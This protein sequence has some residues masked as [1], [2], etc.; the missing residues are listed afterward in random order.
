MTLLVLGLFAVVVLAGVSRVGLESFPSPRSTHLP[1]MGVEGVRK[2]R[3][4]T[5]A[6]L[7][8]ATAMLR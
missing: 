3:K 6:A 4:Q 2:L 5:R 8:A 7:D 1:G